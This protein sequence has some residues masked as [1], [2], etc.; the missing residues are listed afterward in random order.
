[1]TV[2]LLERLPPLL[3]NTRTRE[4]VRF[5]FDDDQ[6][7]Y[8]VPKGPVHRVHDVNGTVDG[9]Q[10]TFERSNDYEFVISDDKVEEIDFDQGGKL[11][12]DGTDVNLDVTYQPIIGR[13]TEAH[14]EEFEFLDSEIEDAISSRQINNASKEEL[15]RIG[16]IFG[17]LG[18]RRGRDDPDY[19]IF[20]RTIVQSFN[21]RGTIEGLR[22]AAAAG[23]GTDTDNVSI[24]EDYENLEYNLIIDDWPSHRGSVVEDLADLADPSVVTLDAVRYQL[25]DSTGI[26]DTVD[27][28]EG[29]SAGETVTV[30]DQSTQT[31]TQVAWNS[32]DW[33]TGDWAQEHN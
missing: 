23:L 2:P 25:E 4:T 32:M 13:Y 11:P 27:I 24:T 12:D 19:K 7:V 10:A 6:L 29:F 16:A 3:Q 21:G 1:M 33:D 17:E 31:V 9:Q 18:E 5:E 22:F 26:D 15:D 8:T 30:D 14:D 28:T 20:L